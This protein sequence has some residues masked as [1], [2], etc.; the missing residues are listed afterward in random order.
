[1]READ[2]DCFA[3]ASLYIDTEEALQKSGDLLGP[4]S[5]GVIDITDVRATLSKL[6]RGEATGRRT[7][8]ERSV[9]KSVGNALEDLAAAMLVFG[10]GIAG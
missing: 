1:M 3:G 8:D 6:S 4:L 5:R 7:A 2:D 10:R 9:F